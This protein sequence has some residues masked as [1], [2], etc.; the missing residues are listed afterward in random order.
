MNGEGMK[1]ENDCSYG[2]TECFIDGPKK[3]KNSKCAEFYETG[4]R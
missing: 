4:G 2:V 1:K 3:G